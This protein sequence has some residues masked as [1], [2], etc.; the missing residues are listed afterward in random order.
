[1]ITTPAPLD[2][3]GYRRFGLLSATIVAALFGL[4]L[5]WLFDFAW[6][7]WPWLVAMTLVV[8]ALVAPR[9]LGPLYSTWMKFGQVMNWINTRLILGFVFYLM[10]LPIGLVMRL[11]GKDPL[12]RSFDRGAES[13]R[14]NNDHSAH[15]NMEHPY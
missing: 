11:L 2:A 9:A 14:R 8:P 7:T 6:P 15:D 5:P 13:Y 10:I 1:M 12:A 3:A 4:A